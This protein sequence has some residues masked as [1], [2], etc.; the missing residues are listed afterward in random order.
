MS[1]YDYIDQARPGLLYGIDNLVEGGWA[2]KPSAGIEFGYPVFTYVGD[3]K[4][5]YTFKNDTGTFVLDA[6]LITAN[7]V[8]ITV[9]GT[10][11][12]AVTFDTDHDTTMGLIV[13]ALNDMT[14]VEAV[15]DPADTNSRTIQILIKGETAVIT[16]AVTLG[17]SQAGVTVTYTTAQVYVGIAVMTQNSAGLYEQYDAVNVLVEGYCWVQ[18]G[19][20]AAANLS[21]YVATTG[22]AANAGTAINLI[23]RSNLAAAGYVLAQTTGMKELGVAAKFA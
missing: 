15:L 20:V 3:E 22:L 9:N 12:A 21:G 16:G 18:C 19:T 6:D 4:D 8:N 10:A 23:F 17:A 7:V 1:A 14:G 5:L 11:M 13:S 2:C